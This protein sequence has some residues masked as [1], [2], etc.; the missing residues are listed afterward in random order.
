[1]IINKS[2]LHRDGEKMTEHSI[3]NALYRRTA[4]LQHGGLTPN[5]HLFGWECDFLSIT[6]VGFIHEYEIKLSVQDYKADFK[7]IQKHQ[8][9]KNGFRELSE[10]ESNMRFCHGDRYIIPNLTPDNK[11]TRKR[12][13]YFWYVCPENIIPECDVPEY[14]GLIYI[15]KNSFYDGTH[16]TAVIKNAPR[17]HKDHA[18]EKQLRHLLDSLYY[19]YWNLRLEK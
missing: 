5:V 19:K 13:N 1:M 6:K 2:L 15:I 4:L 9:I 10:H 8:I 16:G 3:Q 17:L 7:K 18:T 11:I 12:P 14:S